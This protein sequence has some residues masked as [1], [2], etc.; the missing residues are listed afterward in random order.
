M[1]RIKTTTLTSIQAMQIDSLWNEEFPSQLQGRFS[2]LLDG[3]DHF[4]HYLIQD[5]LENVVAWAVYFEKDQEIR[6]SILVSK[7][8]Q[9]KGFGMLLL[10]QL[11]EDLE[12]FYGWVVD[13]NND[14]KANGEMYFSPIDFYVKQGFIILH[15]ER[16]ES[17]LLQAV[18]IKW[19]RD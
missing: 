18:K 13:H 19:K 4:A 6:F 2:S 7:T 17:E 14:L 8:Q 1:K 3:V 9:R 5:E 16:I 15:H 11:K 10:N 12:E